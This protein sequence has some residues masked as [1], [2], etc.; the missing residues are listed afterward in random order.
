MEF[1]IETHP[2]RFF[3]DFCYT[4]LFL[5]AQSFSEKIQ[6]SL[7]VADFMLF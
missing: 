3:Y 5:G 1:Q 7:K 4:I 6:P 2:I